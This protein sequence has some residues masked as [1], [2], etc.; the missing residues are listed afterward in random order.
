MTQR[1][2]CR[3]PTPRPDRAAVILMLHGGKD[4]SPEVV[5]GRS[6]SWRRCRAMQRAIS[7]RAHEAGV[8]GLAAALPAPRLERRR[9][10]GRGRPLGAGAGAT[11]SSATCPSSCSATR[12]AP[13]TAVHVADDPRCVGVVGAGPLVPA[14]RAGRRAWPAGTSSPHT[15][16][17][18]ASRRTRATAAFV[19]RPRR[20][21]ARPSS[22]RHGPGRPLPAPPRR[23]PGTSVA[24]RSGRLGHARPALSPATRR[25][26]IR[27]GGNAAGSLRLFDETKPFRSIVTK[28]D[29]HD[30][31]PR[32]TPRP[33]PRRGRPRAR[34]PRGDPRG[35]RRRRLRPAHH[36]RR[37]HPGQGVQGHALPPLEHQGQPGR[38]TPC[39]LAEGGP[40]A[41]P[42]PAACAAT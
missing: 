33:A 41:R 30:P 6:A 7:R 21:R 2:R 15:A 8:R 19:E 17:A 40:A 27:F 37:R 9:R 1:R 18:T 24:P 25:E 5:D 31:A 39:S 38:S 28:E 29:R 26:Q 3:G 14:R 34:D 32:R 42:T 22:T 23:R 20:G 10:P 11:T 13:G 35:A 16:A 4:R 12:W 36:G